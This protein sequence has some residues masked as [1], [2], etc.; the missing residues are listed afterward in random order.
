MERKIQKD[1]I[2]EAPIREVWQLWTTQEGVT[3]FF[4]PKANV[5]LV[6]GGRYEMLF[7]P[8]EAPGSQGGEGLKV[9]SYLPE[10]MLS[11]EWNAPPHLPNVRRERTHVV[12]QFESRPGDK[13]RVKLSH[14]GW[15][16]GAEWDQAFA[17]FIR[18]WDV[19][20]ARLAYRF[21]V[22][23]IDWNDPYRP[24]DNDKLEI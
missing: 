19:V 12:V 7:N 23:P 1:I 9:L 14:L 21:S 22:G 8:E 3:T 15:K 11:V 10:E 13:T 2:V 6:V 17:Y 24:D 20:L 4:A 5:E 18:A 16:E